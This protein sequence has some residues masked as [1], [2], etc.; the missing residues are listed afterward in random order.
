VQP[1]PYT[2]GQVPRVLAGRAEERARIRDRVGRVATFGEFG[3]VL[4]FHAPRGLGKTSLLRA[5]QT[6]AA[7]VGFVSVWVSATSHGSLLGELV[8]GVDRTLTR[9]DAMTG[10]AASRWRTK[11]DKIHLEIGVPGAKVAA[12]LS[13]EGPGAAPSAPVGAAEDLL[14]DTAALVRGAGSA[15]LL[16]FVDE[17]HAAAA[18]DLAVLLNALQNIDG[19]PSAS[20]LSVFVAGLPSTPEAL[21]RAATF[22]ERTTF[23]PLHRLD[24]Q[25]SAAAITGP[26]AGLDVTWGTD[27][28][29]L[30][31]D[32][33][34]GFPYFLQ[35]LGS[36]T[37]DAAR[38]EAQ[39]TITVDD[40]RAGYPA[41]AEQLAALYR[42]RWK[43]ATAAEQDFMTAMAAA[44]TE[45]VARSAV[46]AA[47]GKHSRALSTP[48][49]RLIEKGIIESAG[50][51]QLQFTLPGFGLYIAQETGSGPAEPSAQ[52]D[53][54]AYGLLRHLR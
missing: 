37:W 7:E 39:T 6:E 20:P 9:T 32:D 3:G 27:A 26:A 43:A 34:A 24:A 49:D 51:G 23:V 44:G 54:T 18:N 53:R 38:P 35:L 22:G 33:S 19:D 2:P 16:V 1:N 30:L 36:A 5:A 21:T 42:A 8:R 4:A 25:D 13:P 29:A 15:G 10:A 47:L 45:T 48:R 52:A 14:H 40:V 50:R 12:D 41:A 11:L 28:V 46:A 17:V 31:V